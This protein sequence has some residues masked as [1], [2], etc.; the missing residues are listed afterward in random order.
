M[1]GTLYF[2]I[3]TQTNNGLG[4]A[5]VLTTSSST[6]PNGVGLLTA[7]YN[8]QALDQSYFDS[9]TNLYL[10]TDGAIAA[11]TG[12]SF[13]GYYCP[14]TPIQLSPT[15]KGLNG[16]TATASFTLN[17]AR[18]LFSTSFTVLPGIG[19]SPT[20]LANPYPNSFA[21]GLPFFYGRQVFTALEGRAAGSGTGPFV[22]F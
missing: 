16:A 22:A 12:L 4:S 20:L 19:A 11:C 7:I 15:L 9:G 10:F 8:G 2:G 1:T 13:A 17:N 3:G 6:S 5:V 21:F 14:P 18:T